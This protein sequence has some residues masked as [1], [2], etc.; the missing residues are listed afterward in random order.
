MLS[1]SFIFVWGAVGGVGD[2]KTGSVSLYKGNLNILSVLFFPSL[3]TT[4]LKHPIESAGIDTGRIFSSRQV[5]QAGEFPQKY[6]SWCAA[7]RFG[8]RR[9]VCTQNLEFLHPPSRQFLHPQTSL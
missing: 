1:F 6:C 5:S 3:P 7:T 8:T 2:G 4:R 9:P